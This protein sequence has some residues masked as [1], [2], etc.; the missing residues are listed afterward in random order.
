MISHIKPCQRS[1]ILIA[2]VGQAKTQRRH[3]VQGSR[4]T[5]AFRLTS[6]F[7]IGLANGVSYNSMASSSQTSVHWS[8]PIQRSSLT[9]ATVPGPPLTF[10]RASVRI[11][12]SASRIRAASFNRLDSS[13]S[14]VVM[15]IR[16]RQFFSNLPKP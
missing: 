3:P 13:S 1:I 9:N 8:H 7:R 16:G 11:E 4:S 5:L 2:S 15:V 14:R 10:S 12:F 6:M